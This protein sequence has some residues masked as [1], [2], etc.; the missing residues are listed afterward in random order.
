[1]RD[2][3]KIRSDLDPAE[4]RLLAQMPLHAIT[5]VHGQVGL[6]KRLLMEIEMNR[7]EP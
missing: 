4:W 2:R 5:S 6:R 1:L 7:D 3:L